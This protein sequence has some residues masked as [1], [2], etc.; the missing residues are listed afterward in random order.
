M[1]KKLENQDFVNS[2]NCFDIIILN[3]TWT[4]KD[5]CLEL[6]GFVCPFAKHR[7][8]RHNAKR[9]SGGIV[10]F[11]KNQIKE[12]VCEEP[13][14]FEDGVIIKLGK[15]FFGLE[16]NVSLMCPY[17]S[18]SSS[19]R[20][21]ANAGIDVF[22]ILFDKISE[23]SNNGHVCLIGDLNSRI[24][25]FNYPCIQDD[26]DDNE[27][28]NDYLVSEKSIF[29][30]DLLT[31]GLSLNRLSK[32]RVTNDYGRSLI[33]LMKSTQ[34]L[35]LN[36]IAHNDKNVGKPTWT[37]KRGNKLLQ[38]VVDYVICSKGILKL[39]D[40]F[41]VHDINIHSDH[42]ILSF[43]LKCDAITQSD[44][45]ESS[46]NVPFTKS[47][48]K[49]DLA[50][51]YQKNI[52]EDE[53]LQLLHSIGNDLK[54]LSNNASSNPNHASG[55]LDSTYQ[56]C[57]AGAAPRD[58]IN[59]CVDKLVQAFEI[60]GN[61]HTISIFPCG[62][63]FEKSNLINNNCWYD[64]DCAKMRDEFLKASKAHKIS[65]NDSDKSMM[66]KIRN[67]YR[68]LCK[69]KRYSQKKKDADELIDLFKTNSR[70]FWRKFKKGKKNKTGNCDFFE[71]F[72]ELSNIQSSIDPN[73][74][75]DIQVSDQNQESVSVEM[76]DE[77]MTMDELET[78][79]KMLKRN[80]ACGVDGILNEFLIFS[81]ALMKEKI[82][83]IFNAI[84]DTGEF[85]EL[86]A[87][88]EIV[89]VFK[90][91]DINNPSDYRGL[92]LISCVAKLFTCLINN[93]L[94]CWAELNDKF[95]KNQY[96]FRK[97]KSVT[98][99]IFIVHG[100]IEHFLS[101]SVPF[102]CSFVD[103]KKAF[104]YT[105]RPCLWH[106]LKINGVSSKLVQLIKNLYSKI[107]LRVRAMATEF[108]TNDKQKMSNNC[109]EDTFLDEEEF[110]SGN[111]KQD[112]NNEFFTSICGVFQ[113]ES[114]SPFLFSMYL[115][116]LDS[117]LRQ[118]DDI[119]V[120]IEQFI[121]TVLL[122]AD[123][124][125]LFSK[126]REGLQNALN[127]LHKYCILW[128]LTVNTA[129][130]K[131]VAFK[132]G[133]RIG[134]KDKWYFD[135]VL[136][137]TVST[138]KYLGFILSSSGK[139]AKS[140]AAL[141]DQ[142]RI[143]LF[144]MKSFLHKYPHLDLKTRIKVFNCLVLPNIEYACEIWGFCAAEKL[145]TFYLGFLKSILG[146]RKTTPSVFI[147]RELNI[148]PLK[149]RRYLRIFKYW[150]KIIEL[151]DN[152]PVKGVY[153]ILK[154]DIIDSPDT[155]NWVSLLKKILDES[156]LGL[157]WESQLSLPENKSY[158]TALF[159]DRIQDIILQ[160]INE[161]LEK[162]SNNRLYKHIDHDFYGKDYLTEI[163]YNHLRIALSKLRL[164]SHNFM[165][166][167]GRWTRPPLDHPNRICKECDE[168]EDEMHIFFECTRYDLLRKQYLPS[169]LLKRPSMAKF[170]DYLHK[171]KGD[172]LLKLSVFIFKVFKHYDTNEI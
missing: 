122:F 86:W 14:D 124:M 162:I 50:E 37:E 51:Q 112:I 89:P 68:K 141:I 59:A 83:E 167:R 18:P 133:G 23:I 85:P 39:V 5:S 24:A 91:G 107:K 165:V 53:V 148:Y 10:I 152:E 134:K 45:Q 52:Q 12:G 100:L 111:E 11:I 97:N 108:C 73:I 2:I 75:D 127:Y 16:E 29:Q 116:D 135:G 155:A 63:H 114:L 105:N 44:K 109:E 58:I 6:D 156:G 154:E 72:K 46:N 27:Y 55:N 121:L 132:K 164:G 123:D 104:D 3:E 131:C 71:Y 99:C 170:I 41:T 48:W 94:N 101:K 126:T 40:N 113:G 157:L 150:L 159:K 137:E 13:W 119:G 102:Y 61:G 35:C 151:P 67:K 168:L 92:C 32:D 149:L 80:K 34:M 138:F 69:H 136:L 158:Y 76:L 125:V 142:G 42:A 143:A 169:Y 140:I 84:L 22:D 38:S 145:D 47:V 146:V 106:K 103:L 62:E 171:A 8:K 4:H 98:D 166:E 19:T 57:V 118:S 54:V 66:C 160:N 120:Q 117:F 82:L 95:C 96:G 30:S 77:K 31:N 81:S 33:N 21:A 161:D 28:N 17:L 144:N 129:K 49:E 9:H 110:G 93:R 36:G 7:K 1:E 88:G 60:A 90:K 78:G 79:I 43:D 25:D 56:N 70:Q 130:T 15:D 163:K 87:T 20:N 153:N 139:F 64:N 147:Y 26:V 74:L 172:D 115:N 128:G 65:N